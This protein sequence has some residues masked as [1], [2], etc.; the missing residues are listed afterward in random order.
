MKEP[1]RG[2]I[3]LVNLDPTKGREQAG[4]RRLAI[5]LGI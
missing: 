1:S 4:S 2:E 3:W 5:L